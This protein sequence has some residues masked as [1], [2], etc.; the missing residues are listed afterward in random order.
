MR[1]TFHRKHILEWEHP[2]PSS[3]F[4]QRYKYLMSVLESSVE[5]PVGC[6]TKSFPSKSRLN[7]SPI[8][9]YCKL[10]GCNASDLVIAQN[11]SLGSRLQKAPMGNLALT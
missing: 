10:S 9:E 7:N 4:G 6:L 5:F 2:F 8:I 1:A 11:P 3:P